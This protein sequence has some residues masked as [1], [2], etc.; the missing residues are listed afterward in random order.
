MIKL[1]MKNTSCLIS[2]LFLLCFP[3]VSYAQNNIELIREFDKNALSAISTFE[4][5]HDPSYVSVLGGV[6]NIEQL[7]FE[8]DIVPYFML[9][10]NKKSRWAIEIS[11]RIIIRMYNNE[12]YP[13]RTPSYLPRVTFFHNI[14]DNTDNKRDLFAYISWYHHSN[15]QD[16][17]FY[18]ADESSIN[19]FSGNFSTNF[20]EGG[21]FISKPDKKKPSFINYHKVSFSYCYFQN[22]ELKPLYGKLRLLYDYNSSISINNSSS[23]GSFLTQSLKLGWIA[24]ALA[25]AKALDSKR[26]IFRYTLSYRPSFLKDVSVFAQYYYGQDYY[27]IYFNR[28]LKVLRFGI[29]AKL[30]LT[31]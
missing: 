19:T 25:Q 15:G 1:I 10:V 9:S 7:I 27:N 18:N 29:A 17:P 16:G 22:F 24:G 6:G 2:I 5:F 8:A 20:I 14:V 23:K 3:S 28:T 26:I 4:M 11:P 30:S 12:S 31:N 13:V 21:A